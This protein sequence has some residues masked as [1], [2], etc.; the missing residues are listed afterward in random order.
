MV[1]ALAAM[2]WA[3]FYL[4]LPWM[5][6]RDGAHP[7]GAK[8]NWQVGTS[9]TAPDSMTRV[10]AGEGPPEIPC[11]DLLEGEAC[12]AAAKFHRGPFDCAGSDPAHR[13]ACPSQVVYVPTFAIDKRE[14]SVGRYQACVASLACRPVTLIDDG[15]G[16]KRDED[17]GDGG[18]LGAREG[19]GDQPVRFVTVAEAQAVCSWDHGKRLPTDDEWELASAGDSHREFPWGNEFPTDSSAVF[20]SNAAGAMARRKPNVVAS[21]PAGATPEGVLDLAG[22]V[23]EWTSTRAPARARSS[24]EGSSTARRWVR[25][26]SFASPPEGLRTFMREAHPEDSRSADLGFRCA[27]TLGASAKTP[28][29]GAHSEHAR[30]PD[31]ALQTERGAVN[32]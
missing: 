32:R 16:E 5:L 2:A 10:A 14:V 9:R 20:S 31:A 17:A 18:V 6:P 25:G 22:N 26:G 28:D 24:S 30:Q 1:V 19:E 8:K 29:G 27:R 7:L 12:I 11:L 4:V 13:A 21:T 23:A 15:G 3:A